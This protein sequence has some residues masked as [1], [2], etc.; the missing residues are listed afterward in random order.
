MEKHSEKS[1]P[2]SGGPYGQVETGF[3]VKLSFAFVSFLQNFYWWKGPSCRNNSKLD[4]HSF[5]TGKQEGGD[6]TGERDKQ[7]KGRGESGRVPEISLM[8]VVSLYLIERR[9]RAGER[10]REMTR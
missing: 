9:R 5:K 1:P 4:I 7:R 6:I 8:A 10:R 2:W 3:E